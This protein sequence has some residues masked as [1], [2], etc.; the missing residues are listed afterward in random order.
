[1]ST[2][3]PPRF[4]GRPLLRTIAWSCLTIALALLG[5]RGA[6]SVWQ[7]LTFAPAAADPAAAS[8]PRARA[9]AERR[10]RVQALVA[11]MGEGATVVD[12]FAS[13]TGLTGVVLDTGYGG[14]VIAW[15][16]DTHE[17]LF[18]GAAFD[19]SGRNISQQ[20]MVARGFATP[21][22]EPPAATQPVAAASTARTAVS[23][24]SLERSAGFLE[25][26]GGPTI[27]AFIDL[28]CA[29]CSRLWRQLRAPLAAGQVRVRWVP[30][31]VLA[32][33][34]EAKAAAL[35]QHP[36]PVH[37]L[38]AH[39]T[40]RASL[41]PVPPTAG[42]R[43]AVAA[44]DALLALLTAGRPATPVLVLR[45]ADQQAYVAIGLPPDLP[46]FLQEAR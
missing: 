11:R 35:L 21:A 9:P 44:N 34:S 39:E 40:R 28:N 5:L 6:V 14:R 1:M 32:A 30:V 15:M 36:D 43:D 27:T 7:Q 16:P 3:L 12:V 19:H 42:V 31:G 23:L 46:T 38:A 33:D 29:F 18:I 20:E 26:H 24:Q 10:A 25:G 37:A 2:A 4:A 22:M 41:T 45:G 8:A 13:P 17:T